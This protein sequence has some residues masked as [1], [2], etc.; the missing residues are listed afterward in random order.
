V[1]ENLIQ[2]DIMT[3]PVI[4]VHYTV[5]KIIKKHLIVF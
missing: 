3:N 5:S 1:P 2:F 4:T